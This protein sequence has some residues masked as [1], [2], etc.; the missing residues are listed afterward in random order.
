LK[1]PDVKLRA[2]AHAAMQK[3]KRLRKL[4]AL[5]TEARNFQ[6]AVE[7]PKATGKS[8]MRK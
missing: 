8:A 1:D 2:A 3:I 7:T 6:A 4:H 5:W